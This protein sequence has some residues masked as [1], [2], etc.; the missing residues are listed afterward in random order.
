MSNIALRVAAALV[1]LERLR[2]EVELADVLARQRVDSGASDARCLYSL[3][4]R[5]I[6]NGT[7]AWPASMKIQRMFGKR[8]GMPDEHDVRQLDHRV[9]REAERVDAEEAVEHRERPLAPVRRRVERHRQAAL[10]ERVE[11]LHVR[12]AVERLVVQAGDHE[13][14][15]ARACR[16][17]A[18]MLRRHC[19]GS[20][21]GQQRHRQQPLVRG[22]TSSTSH[23]LNAQVSSS[24]TCEVGV[25]CRG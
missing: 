17:N 15:H 16:P 25:R 7:H 5:A 20:W 12:V 8:S 3:S 24:R 9:E 6:M 4:S 21:I 14:D 18:S 11:H 19:S 1:A 22:M 2:R 13:A 23:R 10:V